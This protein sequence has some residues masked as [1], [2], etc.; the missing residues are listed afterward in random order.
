[1]TIHTFKLDLFFFVLQNV[2][3]MVQDM[4]HNS[5]TCQSNVYIEDG[6]KNV[7]YGND[8]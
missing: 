5:L 3:S 8:P 7:S 1:M 6:C 4:I 2:E